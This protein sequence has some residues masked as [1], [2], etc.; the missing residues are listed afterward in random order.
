[1]TEITFYT[2]AE[3]KLDIA[4]RLAAK[5]Y[6]QGK[7]VMVYAPDTSTAETLERM[8]WTTPALSFLPHCRDTHALASETPVLIGANADALPRPD[9]MINLHHDWPPAFARFER[10]L[11]IV[12]QDEHDREQSRARYRFYQERGYAITALDLRNPA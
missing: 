12:S 8:L 6:A 9:V 4:R 1:M 7:Q 3:D 5:A 2:F 11:E 10:L